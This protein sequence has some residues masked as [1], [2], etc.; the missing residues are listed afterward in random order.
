MAHSQT[1]ERQIRQPAP[2]P[3][4]PPL[5]DVDSEG[6]LRQLLLLSRGG[7]MIPGGYPHHIQCEGYSGVI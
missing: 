2:P 1:Q 4:I 3:E 6:L 5:P 7:N